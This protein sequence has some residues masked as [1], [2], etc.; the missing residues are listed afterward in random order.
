VGPEVSV[1]DSCS[2]PGIFATPSHF[3]SN[4]RQN[5]TLLKNLISR[6]FKNTYHGHFLGYIWS[7]LEPLAFTG[8]F[9]IVLLILRNE[10]DDLMPLRIMLG[11]L[12][13]SA[14]SKTTSVSTVSL[15][16]NSALIQQIYFPR[17][18]LISSI[19]GF[20]MI[21]LILSL[22]IVV[23][24]MIYASL[25]P[26]HYIFLL[27]V[28]GICA[29]L[30]GNGL[31][32]IF[33]IIHVRFRDLEQIITLMIRLGFYLSGVFF[34]AELIP[35]AYIPA[36]FLNPVAVYIEM[37]RTAITGE[38]GVLDSTYILQ[39]VISSILVYILGMIVFKRYERKAVLYL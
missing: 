9:V 39:A 32:M 30:L 13:Y 6:D 28:A 10:P 26:S 22:F 8:I 36:Y 27:P 19:A 17:E 31:G 33:A 23:P 34:S 1:T 18:V 16:R 5:R 4:L 7:L 2:R 12:I 14:F 24:Y 35:K 15:T 38:I 11:I 37:S 25:Y 3:F 20:Q 29:I 21:K